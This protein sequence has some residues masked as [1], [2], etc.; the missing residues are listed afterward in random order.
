MPMTQSPRLS[1]AELIEAPISAAMVSVLLRG[2]TLHDQRLVLLIANM[3]V[4][5]CSLFR[6]DEWLCL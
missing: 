1:K 4:A 3:L 6:D 5:L 2:M